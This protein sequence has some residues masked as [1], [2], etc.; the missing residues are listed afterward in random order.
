MACENPA[1]LLWTIVRGCTFN[2]D[3]EF[4]TTTVDGSD[5]SLA[6]KV[7]IVRIGETEYRSGTDAQLAVPTPSNGVAQLRM[8][9]ADTAAFALQRYSLAIEIEHSAGNTTRYREGVVQFV[10]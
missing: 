2:Y 8:A 6:G 7:V 1:K 5:Y 3:I 9:D 4:N 10:P